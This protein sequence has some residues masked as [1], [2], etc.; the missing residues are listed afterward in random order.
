MDATSAEARGSKEALSALENGSSPPPYEAPAYPKAR[1]THRLRKLISSRL[2]VAALLLVLSL[3]LVCLWRRHIS[4]GPH[5]PNATLSALQEKRFQSGLSSCAA[6]HNPAARISAR[7]RGENP[8]WNPTSGQDRTVILRNATLFDGESF[9]DE[10]VDIVLAKGLIASVA[11]TAAD[12]PT[13]EHLPAAGAEVVDLFGAYVTPGLVDMH[14]HHLVVPWPHV[15]PTEDVDEEH[16]GSGPLTPFVRAVDGMKPYDPATRLIASGGV[17]SSLVIPGSS[18]VIGGEGAAVKNA[19]RPGASGE[20]VVE[21]MLL[22][23]GVDVGE[24]RRYMKLACGENPKIAYGHT[25]MGNAW[26]LRRWLARARELVD[27]QEAWCEAAQEATTT[28]DKARLL[29]EKGGFPEDLE[30]ESTT[31][32]LRGEVAVHIHCYEPEDFETMIRISREFGFRV[33]AFH[34]AISAW[35]V[36]E[37]LKEY[38]E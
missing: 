24:R 7:G 4:H 35:Q 33:R 6:I 18:N 38:D 16:P 14:S 30:L 20:L 17:T 23:H 26:V 32:V 29:A 10:A 2:R 21:E 15:A 27:R 22:E 13:R 25:R 11:P 37:M 36:P 28:S 1:H 9:L 19:W 34:H 12:G 3:S 8:R 5:H 31:G